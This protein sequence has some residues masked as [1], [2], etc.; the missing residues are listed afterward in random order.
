MR[1]T[2]RSGPPPLVVNPRC[3]HVPVAEKLLHLRDVLSGIEEKRRRGS[4]QTVRGVDALLPHR[5]IIQVNLFHATG[6]RFM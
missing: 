6:S 4:P 1:R 3:G 2:F 5:P